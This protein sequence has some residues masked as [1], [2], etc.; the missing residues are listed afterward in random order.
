VGVVGWQSLQ[1]SPLPLGYRALKTKV[2]PVAQKVYGC[3]R[4]AKRPLGEGSMAFMERETGFEPATSTLA[5]SHSTTEL[6]PLSRRHYKR[7]PRPPANAE[8]TTE[9]K[10]PRPFCSIFG[11]RSI[12]HWCVAMFPRG[13]QSTGGP[14]PERQFGHLACGRS[15]RHIRRPPDCA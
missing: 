10:Y 9:G 3:R 12:R 13:D 14:A 7:A 4:A 5:R 11:A 6:L 2:A 1:T 15:H 8:V